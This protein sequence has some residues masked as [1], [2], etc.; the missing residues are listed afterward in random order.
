[1]SSVKLFDG[2]RYDRWGPNPSKVVVI[3]GKSIRWMG[4]LPIQSFMVKSVVAFSISFYLCCCF[5]IFVREPI[6]HFCSIMVCL[7]WHTLIFHAISGRSLFI[8][9]LIALLRLYFFPYW[10]LVLALAP[11]FVLGYFVLVLRMP[12]TFSL[13]H[14]VLHYWVLRLPSISRCCNLCFIFVLLAGA[15]LT[16]TSRSSDGDGLPLRFCWFFFLKILW[17]L[18]IILIQVVYISA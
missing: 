3:V 13:S 15:V 7:L 9:A 1:M 14:P 16:S 4:S 12:S 11:G 2:N 17:I 18:A 5:W 6:F 10:P 8:K